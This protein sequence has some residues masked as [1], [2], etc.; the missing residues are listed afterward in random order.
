[1]TI[2]L[3]ACKPEPDQQPGAAM[4]E[5]IACAVGGSAEFSESC[6]VERVASNERLL[7]TVHHPDGG[8]R[9]F[10]VMKDGS[11]VAT[12]DGAD[13]AVSKLSGKVLEVA[14]GADRY[15]FPATQKRDAAH[16]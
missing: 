15:R 1:M 9:R 10:Q 8:F 2:V 13:Q 11:G 7:L 16:P 5:M 4:G 6:A 3:S 14:I 12:A